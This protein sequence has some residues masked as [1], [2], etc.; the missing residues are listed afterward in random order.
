MFSLNLHPIF[1]LLYGVA[2][3]ISAWIIYF[4]FSLR[5]RQSH[6]D[7][8]IRTP[9]ILYS[10]CILIWVLSNAFFYS[11]SIIKVSE[12]LI[13]SVALIAN[14]ASF[15][16]FICACSVT[17]ILIAEVESK[18]SRYI[19]LALLATLT[20]WATYLNFAS[21]RTITDVTVNKVGDFQINLGAEAHWFYLTIVILMG[22]TFHNILLYARKARPLRQ[23]KSMYVLT[24]ICIF[25]ISTI[26]FSG[27]VPVLWDN[28]SLTWI[29]PTLAISEILLIGYGLLTSRFFSNRQVVY[30]LC[31]FT[32]TSIVTIVPIAL[33]LNAISIQNPIIA[34]TVSC[35]YTAIV[36]RYLLRIIKVFCSQII[37]GSA[38]S[39]SKRI[40]LLGRD[41]QRSTDNALKEIAK[42]IG[43]DS[44]D[45]QLVSNLQ[46]EQLYTSQ[47]HQHGN[48]LIFQE[49][50]DIV[51]SGREVNNIHYSIYN[52]M[53][54]E[55][56]S[57]VLPIFD[58]NQ[59]LSHLLL[60]KNKANGQMYFFEEVKALQHVLLI[61]QGYINA[62]RKVH[63]SQVLANS[64]AHEMRNPLTQAQYQFEVLD[65]KINHNAEHHE[66]QDALNRGK[67]SI[68]RGRQLIDII[69]REVNNT[70]LEDVPT[71]DVSMRY[72]V[73]QAIDGYAF[74]SET[75]KQRI[76]ID[77]E[78]DFVARINETLFNFV[79]FNLLRNSVYYFDSHPDSKVEIKSQ[80][81]KY[82]H[83]LIVRDT[84]PGIPKP[85]INRIFDD[86]FSYNKS[87]GSGL[88]L[89]YC[90]RV[91]KSFG[92]SIECYSKQGYFTEFHLSFPTSGLLSPGI[93]PFAR[94]H[95][96]LTPN[97]HAPAQITIM[98]VDDNQCQRELVQMLLTRLGYQVVLAT[99]GQDAI[100]TLEK[101]MVDFVLMDIRMPV[102]NGFEATQQIKQCHPALPVFALSGES[103]E[104]E[105]Q[106]IA[107]TMDGR[108]SKPATIQELKRAVELAL[109]MKDATSIANT[110]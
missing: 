108:L 59:R 18:R 27:F 87:D 61:A 3:A 21:N 76:H 67:N 2:S 56:V 43:I 85:L 57:L 101:C 110:A 73:A 41:F 8:K 46:D 88:G 1:I 93:T 17:R 69:L 81:G 104:Y 103:G 53:Q 92:G 25:M 70:A 32:L 16:G 51:L 84:G 7:S 19:Q 66:L 40:R 100:N 47:L 48:V 28:Y 89:G 58:Y 71:N 91:M 39:P 106:K 74:E 45:L 12:P 20:I 22:V 97:V 102:M 82:E 90:R 5:T 6:F 55:A 77:I 4:V 36:W 15:V 79:I 109:A 37:F 86:F 54:A 107:Q 24:G 13:L 94:R 49:I 50:E 98:V 78:H 64:I 83:F 9:Y 63:Q 68:E 105:L 33:V 65:H 60:A 42:I 75:I 23:V 26:V 95:T 99:N 11:P 31:S 35:L 34:V 62:D 52:K 29:P 10:S 80:V 14:T 44:E 30:T 96:A 38:S 72:A